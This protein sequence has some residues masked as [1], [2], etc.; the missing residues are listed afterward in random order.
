MYD[1]FRRAVGGQQET[2]DLGRRQR[3]DLQLRLGGIAPKFRVVE[4]Y[5]GINDAAVRI[6]D[7]P[8][9]R[10]IT[11]RVLLARNGGRPAAI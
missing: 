10:F 8:T 4:G 2:I 5:K 1:R 3:F 7:P 11:A 6:I 9:T